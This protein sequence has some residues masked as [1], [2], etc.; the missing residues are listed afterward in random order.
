MI[1]IQNNKYSE[2]LESGCKS[3]II[4][5]F[6]PT[7]NRSGMIRRAYECLLTQTD[8]HFVWILVNDGSKDNTDIEAE[9]ILKENKIPMLF[10]SKQNGGKH[11][12]FEVAFNECQTEFFMCMDD[13]DIYYPNAVKTF[14]DEW[15]NI[16]HEGKTNEIGAIR[17]LT[18][19]EDGTIVSKL[20][21]D[22]DL[23]GK[24][25]DQ[26]TLESNYIKHENFENWT[27]YRTDAL[28][29][30]DLFPKG[31]WMSSHHKFFSEAIWQGRFARKYMCRYFF[32]ALREYRHDTET[33]II[34]SNKSK[35]HYVDMFINFKMVL[36]EQ[37]DYVIKSPKDF[38]YNVCLVSALRHK[39]RIPLKDLLEHTPSL[40]LKILF[41]ITSPFTILVKNPQ[42]GN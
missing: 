30:I 9:R 42:I 24:H 14:L 36:D 7:Y 32:V 3:G 8:T 20:P 19:E 2:W 40:L 34:R 1:R 5:F 18:Q 25:V 29:D 13:D 10:L 35:Q 16:E 37:L 31:Y 21:F 22:K 26:T 4:T 38:L 17:T 33:S 28:R 11:S 23:L 6:T 27:C 41:T 12:A 15:Q 39:L